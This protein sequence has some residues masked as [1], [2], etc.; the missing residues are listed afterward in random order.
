MLKVHVFSLLFPDFPNAFFPLALHWHFC[1]TEIDYGCK[2]NTFILSSPCL[3]VR[4]IKSHTKNKHNSAPT[5]PHKKKLQEEYKHLMR[6]FWRQWEWDSMPHQTEN[7]LR[8]LLVH[9]YPPKVSLVTVA[10]ISYSFF[11]YSFSESTLSGIWLPHSVSSPSTSSQ[12]ISYLYQKPCFIEKEG[13]GDCVNY[14]LISW[15]CHITITIIIQST[16]INAIYIFFNRIS[17]PWRQNIN[18]SSLYII[19]IIY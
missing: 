6:V 1:F 19:S 4:L 12:S 7:F 16:V 14:S 17:I 8:I 5:P 18:L 10:H 13:E 2:L 15:P 3:K 9:Y 11:F